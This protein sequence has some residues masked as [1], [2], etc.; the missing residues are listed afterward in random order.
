MET[1]FRYN[2]TKKCKHF[3]LFGVTVKMKLTKT[4]EGIIFKTER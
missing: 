4:A 1:F 2:Y 3:C